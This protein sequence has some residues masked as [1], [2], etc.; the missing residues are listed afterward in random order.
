MLQVRS[1]LPLG[2]RD[3]QANEQGPGEPPCSSTTCPGHPSGGAVGGTGTWQV[4][5]TLLSWAGADMKLRVCH[6]D[7]Q[8]HMCVALCLCPQVPQVTPVHSWVV[9]GRTPRWGSGNVPT[10]CNLNVSF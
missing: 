3:A 9:L 7:R 6:G 1:T 8:Q 5:H 2:D 10:F 4:C